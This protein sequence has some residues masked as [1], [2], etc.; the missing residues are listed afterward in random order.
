[1][2]EDANKIT[3]TNPIFTGLNFK[4]RSYFNNI[5]IIAMKKTE[6]KE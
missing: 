5:T 2:N 6:N 3:R 1:M 4:K